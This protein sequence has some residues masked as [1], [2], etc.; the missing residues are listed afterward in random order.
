VSSASPARPRSAP[1]LEAG[2]VHVWHARLEQHRARLPALA[3]S[4]SSDERERADRFRRRADGDAF[5]LRRGILRELVER[6]LGVPA[7]KVRFALASRDKP[8]LWPEH[9][10]TR[11]CFNAASSEG[12]ALYAFALGR[13]VG[14]DV[15]LV[16]PLPDVDEV[17]ERV[18]CEPERAEFAA[19]EGEP[20]LRA[21]FAAWT[22]KEAFVKAHGD[23]FAIELDGFAVP[24]AAAPGTATVVA[25]RRIEVV[26]TFA[27]YAAAVAAT[28]DG[29]RT[30]ALSYS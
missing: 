25:G 9:G 10:H 4:L 19:L 29:W 13:A 2:A 22:Q 3:A 23:G 7:A 26:D 18:L 28:G 20:R 21:F 1:E 8:F 12:V 11:L 27:G 15:E 14:V 16:R 30:E 6:Y 5:I 17:A 24:L